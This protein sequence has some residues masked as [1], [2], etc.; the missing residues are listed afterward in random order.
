MC[1]LLE[2]INQFDVTVLCGYAWSR[3]VVAVLRRY[4]PTSLCNNDDV[5]TMWSV[6][7]CDATCKLAHGAILE[8]SRIETH[9]CCSLDVAAVSECSEVS[10]ARS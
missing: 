1:T 3:N 5:I 6:Q 7:A 8:K 4:C 10:N 9:C 2:A